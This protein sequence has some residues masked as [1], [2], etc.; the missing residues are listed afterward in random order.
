MTLQTGRLGNN[1]SLRI[2]LQYY[3]EQIFTFLFAHFPET[4]YL[5]PAF[6]GLYKEWYA[7]IKSG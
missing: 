4:S 6:R 3:P 5:L 7:W 2:L 1:V